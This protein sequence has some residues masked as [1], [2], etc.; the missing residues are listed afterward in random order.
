MNEN[1][2]K[3][4]VDQLLS[5]P[6]AQD[7]R[8]T[9]EILR[10]NSDP[11]LLHLE[12]AAVG[13][14]VERARRACWA[15]GRVGE[16]GD[17]ESAA[18]ILERASHTYDR[19][20]R[21]I[22]TLGELGSHGEAALFRI[23]KR[24]D[25]ASDEAFDVL[26]LKYPHRESEVL[27]QVRENLRLGLPQPYHSIVLL[28]RLSSDAED[29]LSLCSRYLSHPKA[30]VRQAVLSVV[31]RLDSTSRVS[32]QI[33]EPLRTDPDPE[34]RLRAAFVLAKTEVSLEPSLRVI[35]GLLSDENPRVAA[36][37]IEGV[38]EL[39][40]KLGADIVYPHV[41]HSARPR[42]PEH[43]R[44]WNDLIGPPTPDD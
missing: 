20:I 6:N 34:V 44:A 43:R 37:A 1:V 38:R 22:R 23:A 16:G 35:G 26:L 19:L 15:I 9:I 32:A 11:A 13:M 30:L 33:A 28:G 40:R 10:R 17:E 41:V 25:G 24:R 31:D 14:D 27:E 2:A 4:A 12:R 36:L 39:I 18:K 21:S 5:N 8:D 29:A 42:V 7:A 3:E